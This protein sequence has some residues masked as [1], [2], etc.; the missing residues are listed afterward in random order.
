LLLL[1]LLSLVLPATM[2]MYIYSA[3]T[4]FICDRWCLKL[5]MVHAWFNASVI[6]T[7]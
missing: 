3:A 2:L 4:L 5:H 1:L 6:A 7:L